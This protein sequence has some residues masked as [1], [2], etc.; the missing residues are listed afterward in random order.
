MNRKLFL[1]Q[2]DPSSAE[3]RATRLRRHGWHV[4]VESENG[5]RAYRLIRTS[6]PDVLVLDLRS[7]AAH[8][9]EVGGALRQLRATRTLPILCI[10]EGDDAREATRAKIPDALFTTARGLP[11]MLGDLSRRARQEQEQLSGAPLPKPRAPDVG[12]ASLFRAVAPEPAK[13]P[14]SKRRKLV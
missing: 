8:G 14:S 9:R 2:W 11:S 1:V 3:K 6:V 7:R 5:G 13:G 12:G 4:D 10:E